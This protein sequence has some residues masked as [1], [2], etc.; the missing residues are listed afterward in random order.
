MDA[1]VV[2]CCCTKWFGFDFRPEHTFVMIAIV[3]DDY[4]WN[5]LLAISDNKGFSS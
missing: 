5:A 4:G 1:K 2:I 3:D